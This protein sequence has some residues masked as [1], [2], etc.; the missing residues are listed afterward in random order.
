MSAFKEGF[1]EFLSENHF[2]YEERCDDFF[3]FP[4]LNVVIVLVH[5]A[6]FAESASMPV[7][8]GSD[9]VKKLSMP[10]ADDSDSV[11]KLS[12]PLADGSDSVKRLSM[13]V[14]DSPMPIGNVS[15]LA[16]G[17][18]SLSGNDGSVDVIYLYEDRWFFKKELVQKRILA[19]LGRFISVFARK[20][21]VMDDAAI[22][23]DSRKNSAIKAFLNEYHSY[24]DAMCKYR[25]ALEYKG[26]IVAVATFSA[27]RPMKRDGYGETIFDSYEWV[28]YASLPD[29]R[30]VGGMGK[31]LKKFLE[32][33]QMK[34][35]GSVEVMSYSDIEWSQG[36]VYERLGFTMV[37]HRDAVEFVVNT[38]T[39][40]RVSLNKISRQRSLSGNGAYNSGVNDNYVKIR[41]MGSNKYLYHPA[42]PEP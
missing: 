20:C 16:R 1:V 15:K 11:K 32:D 22:K 34:G 27:P 23:A 7:A 14:A 35:R 24:G 4:A 38:D 9:S 33:V 31:L 18:S 36:E 8:D 41:N 12:M 10:V 37:Q 21:S 42:A 40:E 13:P 2:S 26:K 25:Y 28:R 6:D 19:R 3:F 29:H 30:V 17:I 39:F 5:L